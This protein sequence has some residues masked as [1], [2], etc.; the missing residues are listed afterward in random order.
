MSI[1]Y[2]QSTSSRAGHLY[3]E[4][5]WTEKLRE[6]QGDREEKEEVNMSDE[7]ITSLQYLRDPT[8]SPD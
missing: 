5:G 2:C 7:P 6:Q 3:Q 4:D 8:H 1:I